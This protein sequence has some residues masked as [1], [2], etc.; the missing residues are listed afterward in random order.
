MGYVT[1]RYPYEKIWDSSFDE[2]CRY[3]DS[4]KFVVISDRFHRKTRPIFF[5]R[6][7]DSNITPIY[8]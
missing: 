5:I 1:I 7:S 8:Y 4:L 3:Y 6:I 2:I